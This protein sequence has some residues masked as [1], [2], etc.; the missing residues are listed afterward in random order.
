M[1]TDSS[2]ATRNA[3]LAIAMEHN[4]MLEE[5]KVAVLYNACFGGFTLS[6]QALRRYCEIKGIQCSQDTL[7]S[8]DC[9][10]PR[11]DPDMVAVVRELGKAANGPCTDL[12]VKEIPRK[13]LNY[14]YIDEYDG[15]ESVCI[16]YKKYKLDSIKAAVK[17]TA[18]FE[19]ATGEQRAFLQHI[20]KILEE[21]L[22]D[23][24]FASDGEQGISSAV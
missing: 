16:D 18:A 7:Y 5:P 17:N 13:F 11:H 14:Y 24:E 21:E 22:E 6:E 12:K 8:V 19:N 1:A 10:V 23:Y 9:G 20:S 3:G 2:M 4:F 15:Y